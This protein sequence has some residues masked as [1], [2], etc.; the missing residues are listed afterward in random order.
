MPKS[1]RGALSPIMISQRLHYLKA[2]LPWGNALQHEPLVHASRGVL[3]FFS[4]SILEDHFPSQGGVILLL[5][6]CVLQKN[7]Q[8]LF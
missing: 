5:S 2:P 4:I 3:I 6:S 7:T 8:G 1:T